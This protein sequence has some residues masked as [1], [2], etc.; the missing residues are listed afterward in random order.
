MFI[1]F[2]IG[3]MFSTKNTSSYKK[4]KNIIN[5]IVITAIIFFNQEVLK[6]ISTVSK[7]NAPRLIRILYNIS[8][9]SLACSNIGTN[10]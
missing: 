8:A 4:Q 2:L 10:I 1:L 5:N 6:L 3:N 7:S 9:K